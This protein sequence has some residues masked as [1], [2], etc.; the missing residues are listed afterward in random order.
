[1]LKY[2]K[3]L[4]LTCWWHLMKGD[5]EII[6]VSR[7]HPLG[8]MNGFNIFQSAPLAWLKVL[9]TFTLNTLTIKLQKKYILTA[10]LSPLPPPLALPSPIYLPICLPPL[11]LPFCISGRN[12]N[13]GGWVRLP[14]NGQLSQPRDRAL[15]LHGHNRA[16]CLL[17]WG[18]ALWSWQ[19]GPGEGPQVRKPTHTHK[20]TF[21]NL[22]AFLF[23][24]QLALM[25]IKSSFTALWDLR[26]YTFYYVH[27]P[28]IS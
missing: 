9:I 13:H 7:L 20:P 19:E 24:V 23:S 18:C 2:F 16:S 26:I 3:T 10:L 17:Q 6:T 11:S 21:A 14:V 27:P 8:I 15:P 5:Q 28:C 25:S 4:T 22:Y 1:M 12:H